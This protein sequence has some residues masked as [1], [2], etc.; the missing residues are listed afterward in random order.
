M[1]VSKVSVV[2]N[3]IHFVINIF[4]MLMIL[5]A[6]V[7]ASIVRFSYN[8]NSAQY[9][10]YNVIS[11]CSLDVFN[12][13][14]AEYNITD[15]EDVYNAASLVVVVTYN[16]EREVYK[17]NVSYIVE[18]ESVLKGNTSK[19]E[20]LKVLE[21]TVFEAYSNTVSCLYGNVP[22]IS[23]NKYLLLLNEQEQHSIKS[24]KIY[25]ISTQSP[26]GK[27]LIN[28]KTAVESITNCE[29][30]LTEYGNITFITKDE[31]VKEMYD[32][33]YY[34][35]EEYLSRYLQYLS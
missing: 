1:E 5:I 13:I 26:I 8:N 32:K 24:D 34:Q 7:T 11:D 15:F 20:K 29:R 16:G 19:N 14:L 27:Y 22:F 35:A 9:D 23:G 31:T 28:G 18:V 30:E 33:F 4:I 3:K 25:Y 2:M 17:E 21:Y 10:T 12:N 6:L